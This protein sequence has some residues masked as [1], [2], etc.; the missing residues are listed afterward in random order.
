MS[1]VTRRAIIFN[2]PL[3]SHW[4]S[5]QYRITLRPS[6]QFWDSNISRLEIRFL[7]KNLKTR[8]TTTRRLLDK[9]LTNWWNQPNAEKSIRTTLLCVVIIMTSRAV[10]RIIPALAPRTILS[11]H[12]SSSNK[13]HSK[14][15]LVSNLRR[16]K[17]SNRPSVKV[18]SIITVRVGV[19]TLV[20]YNL[21]RSHCSQVYSFNSLLRSLANL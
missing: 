4:R 7:S 16:V 11:E 13:R 1:A 19:T 2:R 8:S 17:T 12:N 9:R 10:I 21:G 5:M 20:R 6:M 15:K 18:I 14:S 3:T